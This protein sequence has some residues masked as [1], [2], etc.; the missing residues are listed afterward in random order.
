MGATGTDPP[1]RAARANFLFS[2]THKISNLKNS[3]NPKR[4]LEDM[5]KKT[6]FQE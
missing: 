3:R 6:V 2:G 4:P 1:P 5:E